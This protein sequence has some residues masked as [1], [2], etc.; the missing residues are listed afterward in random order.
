MAEVT[1]KN[2]RKEYGDFVAL[3]GIDFSVADGEF[4]TLLGPSGCGKTTT[5]RLIAGLL[6]PDGG[7][8]WV[9]DREVA[10]K[11][12]SLPPDKRNMGMVFQSYAVWPH[13]DVS[14]NVAYGLK[15]RG[16]SSSQAS[17][18]VEEALGLVK[19]S[20][21]GDRYPGQLSGGQ[22][23][24]VALA[25]SLAIE[26]DILLLD[27]PLSNLDAKLR[28][29]MRFELKEIQRR[30]GITTVYV[31]HDQAEAM[32]LSDR[33]IIMNDGQIEQVDS[34]WRIYQRPQSRFV[35][36][37]VGTSNFFDGEVTSVESAA[38]RCV[39]RLKDGVE[40][41]AVYE[42]DVKVGDRA[43][44]LVRPEDITVGDSVDSAVNRFD[45]VVGRTT[46]LGPYIDYEVEVAN[47]PIRV[48]SGSRTF[49]D[50]GQLVT[51]SV[52]AESC[53]V[54]PRDEKA[55]GEPHLEEPAAIGEVTDSG[56]HAPPPL[57]S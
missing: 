25:R 19:L 37:F 55:S 7:T 9:G 46:Y 4:V 10:S 34:A 31:T 56:E 51:L 42:V 39:V 15:V 24:R 32:A 50:E 33:V 29:D 57:A 21:L 53:F 26:P 8:V 13:L 43:K 38:R 20:G 35:A 11:R 54:L 44:V 40:I 1:V 17:G 6:A 52:E 36:D 28:E 2:L 27:E 23:Q 45:G 5:L 41:T 16:M 14:A 49:V 12:S 22:Q 3:E 48:Q 30:T 47:Q 18:R